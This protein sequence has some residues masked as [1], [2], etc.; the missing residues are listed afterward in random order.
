MRR[1]RPATVYAIFRVNRGSCTQAGKHHVCCTLTPGVKRMACGMQLQISANQTLCILTSQTC[2]ALL[3]RPHPTSSR[4]PDCTSLAHQT[5]PQS[6][7]INE[8]LS[9][10]ILSCPAVCLQTSPAGRRPAR[11]FCGPFPTIAWLGLALI[12]RALTTFQEL[13]MN[14]ANRH[15]RTSSAICSTPM[16]EKQKCGS[17][18]GNAGRKRKRKMASQTTSLRLSTCYLPRAADS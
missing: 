9:N 6:R 4:T 15:T 11:G 1:R 3:T 13:C 18:T 8:Q 12:T 14:E 10:A 17:N 5:W 16:H 2:T 7:W